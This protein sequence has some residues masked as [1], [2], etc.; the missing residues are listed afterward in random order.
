MKTNIFF[1]LVLLFFCASWLSAISTKTYT[2]DTDFLNFSLDG[3]QVAGS[4]DSAKMQ[5]LHNWQNLSPSNQPS[6]RHSAS[7][8]YDNSISSA[9]LFGGVNSDNNAL[10]DTWVYEPLKNTWTQRFPSPLP[11]PRF[12]HKMVN[13]GSGTFLL[14]GGQ[15]AQGNVYNDTW[16]YNCRTNSW[17]QKNFSVKP[18]SRSYQGMCFSAS[19]NKVYMFGG[20]NNPQLLNDFWSYNV[21]ADSWSQ[22]N[23]AGIPAARYGAGMCFNSKNNSIILTCGRTNIIG[24]QTNDLWMFPT[25]G[26]NWQ[27]ISQTSPNKPGPVSDFVF[28]YMPDFSRC[29]LF[30][31]YSAGFENTAILYN[32]DAN[33]WSTASNESSP[34]GRESLAG[35]IFNGNTPYIFGGNT[36]SANNETWK[37]LLKSSATFVI[38]ITTSVPT[39]A[40]WLSMITNS[41]GPISS[42]TTVKY[43]IANSEDGVNWGPYLGY[44]GLTSSYYSGAGPH[45]IWPGEWD[46]N[47]L[48]IKGEMNT[49]IPPVSVDLPEIQIT[50][51]IRPYPPQVIYPPAS[52]RINTL[53]PVFAWSKATDVDGDYPLVY[54]LQAAR[55]NS[56]NPCALDVNFIPETSS[57]NVTYS[58]SSNLAEGQWYWRLNSQDQNT[59]NWT[60][61]YIFYI[62]TRAPSNVTNLSAET[63]DQNGEIHLIWVT[64]G[65][66]GTS[67]EIVNGNAVIRYTTQSPIISE[68]DWNNAPGETVQPFTAA[69][70]SILYSSVRDLQEAATYFLAMKVQDPAGNI[71]TLSVNNPSAFTNAPPVVA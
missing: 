67:G 21:A 63:G 11:S 30:G 22:I 49:T 64:P 2:T 16:I 39:S 40:V 32:P 4:G 33:E 71:S 38:T 43:Q 58:P 54:H 1:F 27:N 20:I 28:E 61:S 15:D 25:A 14:F 59:S 69:V 56:F 66:D 41:A 6:A 42:S 37:Y 45:T 50:Y 48:Q 10:Q 68:S 44:N 12:G 47:Y 60:S 34:S 18:S 19:N 26:N 70:K 57:T 53:K 62:D 3:I 55:D 35:F 13:I 5:I 29:F 7:L 46:K 17:A 8:S 65:D 31:G 51:N 9:V 52:R 24:G 23:T 36:G